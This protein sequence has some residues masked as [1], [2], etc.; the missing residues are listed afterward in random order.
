MNIE[1]KFNVGDIVYGYDGDI[2]TFIICGI[3]VECKY[4]NCYNAIRG[5]VGVYKEPSSSIMYHLYA[6]DGR[7][8]WETEDDIE[9][10]MF[11]SLEHLISLI[12]LNIEKYKMRN[13]ETINQLIEDEKKWRE[14]LSE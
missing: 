2:V 1:T 6:E 3:R 12:N 14:N 10:E 8:Y 7:D 4:G 13:S 9:N 11:P 5:H